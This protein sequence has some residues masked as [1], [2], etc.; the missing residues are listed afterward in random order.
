MIHK[1]GQSADEE[2]S[3]QEAS[4]IL[5]FEGLQ[6]STLVPNRVN[7]DKPSGPIELGQVGDLRRVLHSFLVLA[8]NF[9][10]PG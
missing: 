6:L 9:E 2:I 4:D 3:T 10:A 8:D 7:Q 5:E 1:E